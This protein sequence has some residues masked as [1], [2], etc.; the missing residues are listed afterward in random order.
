VLSMRNREVTVVGRND[1]ICFIDLFFV[2][3]KK[4]IKVFGMY[5]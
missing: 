5:R 4:R 1:K 2:N 3:E